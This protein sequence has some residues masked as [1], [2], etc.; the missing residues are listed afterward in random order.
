[1]C[2]EMARDISCSQMRQITLSAGF[3]LGSSCI[4]SVS[5]V[6]HGGLM[7]SLWERNYGG[8]DLELSAEPCI[9]LGPAK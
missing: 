3:R 4:V 8:R 1:M 5:R 2:L 6:P 9:L 7:E